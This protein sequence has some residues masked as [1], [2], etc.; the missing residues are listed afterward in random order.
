[1]W[2]LLT[3]RLPIR[4]FPS[5]RVFK[6][7]NPNRDPCVVSWKGMHKKPDVRGNTYVLSLIVDRNER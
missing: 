2:L 3:W 7:V 6:N 4:L 5:V 1:M